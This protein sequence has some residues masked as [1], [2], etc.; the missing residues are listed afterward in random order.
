M[1][2]KEAKEEL[3]KNPDFK[4][5]YHRFDLRWELDKIWIQIKYWWYKFKS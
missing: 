1:N 2:L 3:M 5:E 4:K